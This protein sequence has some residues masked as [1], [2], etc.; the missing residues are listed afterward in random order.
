MVP[1]MTAA[2]AAAAPTVAKAYLTA[3]AAT[4]HKT[5]VMLTDKMMLQ[6]GQAAPATQHMLWHADFLK[7]CSSMCNGSIEGWAMISG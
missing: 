6:A 7:S 3:L 5:A 2:A 1:K 4:H